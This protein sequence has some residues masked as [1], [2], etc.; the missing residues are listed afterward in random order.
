MLINLF[1]QELIKNCKNNKKETD[2]RNLLRPTIGAVEK[3][4][5]NKMKLFGSANQII[6]KNIET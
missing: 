2:P 1:C 3:V 5:L 6:I 4:A